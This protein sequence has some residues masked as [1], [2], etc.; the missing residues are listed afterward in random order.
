MIIYT[1]I[2]IITIR[3]ILKIIIFSTWKIKYFI[4]TDWL[5]L[6]SLSKKEKNICNCLKTN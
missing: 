4:L 6:K 3:V 2:S 5:R 1:S